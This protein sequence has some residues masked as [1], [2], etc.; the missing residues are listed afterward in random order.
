VLCASP[1]RL[2][3]FYAA[4]WSACSVVEAGEI[5]SRIIISVSKEAQRTSGAPVAERPIALPPA[6][7]AECAMP[8]PP[9][10]KPP[11]V[12]TDITSIVC[13]HCGGKSRLVRREPLAAD[14]EGEMLTFECEKCGKQWK[15]SFKTR[16]ACGAKPQAGFNTPKRTNSVTSIS[17]EL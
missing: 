14:V 6:N 9:E 7:V 10:K 2:F 1:L 16:P 11:F 8:R 5:C 13:R 17:S 3:A 4:M 12:P 15:Q